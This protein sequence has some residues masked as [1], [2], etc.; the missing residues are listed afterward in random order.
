MC[1][2]GE[3]SKTGLTESIGSFKALFGVLHVAVTLLMEVRPKEMLCDTRAS[4]GLHLS[5]FLKPHFP[6]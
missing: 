6:V 5:R 1:C 3:K 4:V 2:E